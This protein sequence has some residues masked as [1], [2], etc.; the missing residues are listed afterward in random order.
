MLDIAIEGRLQ[1]TAGL[2]LLE[3]SKLVEWELDAERFDSVTRD[4]FECAIKHFHPVFGRVICWIIFSAGAEFLAKRVC[5]RHE[6]RIRA[7][8]CVLA[9]PTPDVATW[10]ETFQP[11]SPGTLPTTN[12]GEIGNLYNGHLQSLFCGHSFLQAS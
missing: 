4:D 9:Y 1:I 12:F 10:L 6:I 8:D 3:T 11:G 2:A 5:L 7:Q